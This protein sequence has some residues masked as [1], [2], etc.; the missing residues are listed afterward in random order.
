MPSTAFRIFTSAVRG[1]NNL[2]GGISFVAIAKALGV[3][4]AAGTPADTAAAKLPPPAKVR[5][6]KKKR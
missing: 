1:A 5:D 6:A 2:V 3:Q 4:K